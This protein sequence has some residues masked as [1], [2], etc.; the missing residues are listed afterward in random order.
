M[1]WRT[2]LGSGGGAA[3]TVHGAAVAVVAV[4]AALAALASAAAI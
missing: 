1:E 3:T 4:V 2:G